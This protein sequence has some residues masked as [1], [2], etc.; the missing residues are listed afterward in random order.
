MSRVHDALRRAERFGSEPEEPEFAVNEASVRDSKQKVHATLLH[1]AALEAPVEAPATPPIPP[2]AESLRVTREEPAPATT[3]A[4][5]VTAE[6][7]LFG[8]QE[9]LRRT[10]AEPPRTV[11]EPGQAMPIEPPKPPALESPVFHYRGSASNGTA[12]AE[13][14]ANVVEIPFRPAPDAHLIDWRT[15]Q[16]TPSEEFRSLRTRLNHL[17]EVQPLHTLVITSPSPAEGKTLTATNLALAQ[18]HLAENRVLLADF[19]LRRPMIHTLLQTDRYPGLSDYL[20][21][22]VPLSAALRK[23]ADTNLYVLPAGTPVK[24]PLELLNLKQAKVL[25]EDLPKVFQWSIFDTP[26]LLFSADANLLSTLAD[27]TLL[28]VRIGETTFDNVI[29]AMQ[30]LCENNVLGI[31]A[32][33]ARASELY[34]KYTYYYSRPE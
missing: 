17:K 26:P 22:H 29:R 34:S 13:L 30:S 21:G 25:L 32:N 11:Y 5:A 18:A 14:L 27:G 31:V 6:P 7:P 9:P 28:V 19:D 16:D 33:G 4:P 3:G 12:A 2:A 10:A 24:N 15:P 23:I 8:I 20:L 1:G